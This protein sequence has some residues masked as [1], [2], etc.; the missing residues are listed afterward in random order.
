MNNNSYRYIL[1]KYRGRSTRHVCPGC[2]RKGAFTRYIDTHNNNIY[3]SERVGKCNRLDKCGYHYTPHQYFE[4]NPWARDKGGDWVQ[5]HGAKSPNHHH[6]PAP[7]N[8]PCFL[9]SLYLNLLGCK[10][11]AHTRWLR[12]RYG[13]EAAARVMKLYKVGATTAGRERREYTIF[14]QI[15]IHG[16][17]RTGKL[18]AY[19]PT[20]G[21]RQKSEGS[22]TW[23]HA[24]LRKEGVV[25]E[26]WELTQSLYGE[27]LLAE[28]PT[29]TVALVEAAKTAHVGA[30]TMPEMVWLSTE[31][32]MGLCAERLAVLKARDVVLFPDEGKGFEV[33]QERIADIARE[34]GFRY[35]I[36][37]FMEHRGI[38]GGDIADVL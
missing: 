3:V 21:K 22:C 11:S 26:W 4:D 36:S 32:M 31:G 30:I 16:R 13:E 15:D 23:L 12:A 35:R 34:V 1:E 14:W 20:T 25:P 8:K 6:H 38:A 29:A 18:I 28:N 37:R 33:W 9:P 24:L 27:H 2:G 19:D 17:L 7:N 5:N 10:E